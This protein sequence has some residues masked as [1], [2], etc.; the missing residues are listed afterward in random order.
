MREKELPNKLIPE[1][2]REFSIRT[3]MEIQGLTLEE[4]AE[5]YRRQARTNPDDAEA[6]LKDI[7][8]AVKTIMWNDSIQKK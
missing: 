5:E 7:E 4:A 2:M 8:E 1:S 3:A 6:Q